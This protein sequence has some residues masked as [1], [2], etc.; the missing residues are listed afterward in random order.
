MKA[1]RI[2]FATGAVVFLLCAVTFALRMR[3]EHSRKHAI[4]NATTTRLAADRGD[5]KAQTK[6]GSMYYYG[7]GVPQNYDEALTWYRKA[8]NQDYPRAEYN[9]GAMYE[10]GKGLPINYT[11][12][13]HWY[14][15]AADHGE[16]D[17]QCSLG[18]MYYSGRG[19]EP[20][21]SIALIWFRRAAD[22]GLAR[23]QYDIAYMYAH[24]E[25]VP[26][27]R[28]EAD[29]WYHKA[30]SQEYDPAL[31]ILGLRGTGLSPPTAMELMAIFFGCLWVLNGTLRSRR[32]FGEFRSFWALSAGLFGLVYLGSRLYQ[33]FG[34]FHSVIVVDVFCL[35]EN[36]FFGVSIAAATCSFAPRALKSVMGTVSILFVGINAFAIAYRRF[37]FSG[38]SLRACCAVNGALLGMLVSVALALW[39]L[40]GDSSEQFS[41]PKVL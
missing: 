2:S 20:D 6:L 21:N 18:G 38:S 8:A 41:I 11:E 5:A 26:Q 16:A 31:R 1:T 36:F 34:T 40:R 24:G 10:S 29:L 27:D 4:D 32:R 39:M 23:A 19:V 30:A 3:A 35:L 17:A 13:L 28:L 9:I 37:A 12:A 14:R 22:Q 7:L 25:G 15:N 33:A